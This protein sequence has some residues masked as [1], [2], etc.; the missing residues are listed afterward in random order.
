[1]V[2]TGD[3]N[4]DSLCPKCLDVELILLLIEPPY[5]QGLGKTGVTREVAVNLLV[6]VSNQLDD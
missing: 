2:L 6:P 4:L 3:K 5:S 1:M